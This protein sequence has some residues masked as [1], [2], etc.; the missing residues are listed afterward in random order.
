MRIRVHPR[1]VEEA[2]FLA[3]R[4]RSGDPLAGA[5]EAW[6]RRALE[7]GYG[8]RPGVARETR[9][10]RAH[11][12]VLGRLGLAGAL[13]SLFAA[14]AALA[15][16]EEGIRVGPAAGPGAEGMDL[17]ER[18]EADGSV[19]RTVLAS[20]LPDTLAD[21]AHLARRMH[22]HASQMA[23]LLDPA[24]AWNPGAA[25]PTPGRRET[26]RVRYGA[27]WAAWTD[28]R[29]RR[30]GLPTPVGPERARGEF[31]EAFAGS[32]GPVGWPVAFE[33]IRAAEA[34][35]HGDLLRFA[36]DPRSLLDGAGAVRE[37]GGGEP[38]DRAEPAFLPGGPCPLC[39]FPT[40]DWVPEPG[41]LG[42]ALLRAVRASRPAWEPAEGIC[43]H[44]SLLFG[45]R[46]R[47][48]PS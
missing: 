1:L 12:V 23:D 8:T 31:A 2:V 41:A 3:C 45:A 16:A 17:H 29:L 25:E 40:H 36:R 11:G 44:C 6:L 20:L 37:G 28:G 48:L 26:V 10:E 39:R 19:I 15:R 34:M 46:V 43:G 32:L 9:F 22:R 42:T 35:T 13:R 5:A 18:R 21:P 47:S 30:R 33:R 14:H 27:A 4:S 24:F 38:G 7:R